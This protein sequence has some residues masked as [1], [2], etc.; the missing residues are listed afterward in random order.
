MKD[1]ILIVDDAQLNREMLKEI[2]G[3]EYE[4]LE[5][6]NGENALDIVR[7]EMTNIAAILLD[8]VMPVMDG[9]SFI[10][11][12]KNLN[13]MGK[14]PI[15]VISGEKSVQN[16]KKCFDYGVS[17]FI[18]RP[19]NAV[20][21]KK[22]VQNVVNHYAYK[23][24]L[25]EKVEEQTAILRKAYNTLKVQA[26]KLAKRNRDIVEM[27]GNMVEYRNLESGEHVQRVKGYTK[28]LAEKFSVEYPEYGLDEDTIK[29]IVDTSAL[30]DIGK[31]AIP[32]SILLKPGRLTKDE[33]E[34]MKSHT[35]RGYEILDQMSKEWDPN[36]K[37]I[38]M[39]IVRHHHERYD[40]KGYPDGLKGDDIPISAQLV[41][42]AD[43]Y[44]ALVNE[45]CYKSAYSKEQ[46]FHMIVNGEC[47][48]FSPKL[49]ETF[50]NV[51]TEFEKFADN[52]ICE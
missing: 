38:S 40:G 43:V 24:K 8:L 25:E 12:L 10:M 5:A 28:L 49:I 46:A 4:V 19:F 13:I 18:G 50:R 37:R 30:H 17:D 48:V 23:N 7:Y 6:E 20:L 31:I 29:T 9:F 1:K 16:E 39:E 22:R 15:L 45:R 51:R 21:V 11:E 52:P 35:I 36:L 42:L 32:D 34:Y 3:E 26:E 2:L 27:L 44:D 14:V 33:F 47:G 41:S